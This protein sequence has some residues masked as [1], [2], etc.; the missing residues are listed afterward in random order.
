MNKEMMKGSIDI[1]LLSVLAKHD[2]YGYEIVQS[3]KESSDEMYS[4]SEG[5][6]YP[7][8]KRLETQGYISSYWMEQENN[9]PRKYYHLTDE[10]EK[11]LKNKL[12]DWQQINQLIAKWTKGEATYE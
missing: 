12:K 11:A 4:M 3:L 5:T 2:S 8:L 10:G 7:A 9:R 1:L 6:M